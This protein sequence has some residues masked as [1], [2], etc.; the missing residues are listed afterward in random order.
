[1]S[2]VSS[3]KGHKQ[4]RVHFVFDTKHYGLHNARLV[5]DGHLTN[6]AISS[7]SGV[8]LLRGIRLILFLAE[9]KNL[10]SW[11]T[12]IWNACLEEFTK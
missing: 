5:A 7:F 11:R 1:M 8:V 6:V 2:K 9:L 10:C 4:I 3:P 12:D